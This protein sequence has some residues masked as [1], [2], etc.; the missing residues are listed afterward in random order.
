MIGTFDYRGRISDCQQWA[1]KAANDQ[2]KVLWKEMERFWREREIIRPI[3]GLTR[4]QSCNRIRSLTGIQLLFAAFSAVQQS[5]VAT[6][7]KALAPVLVMAT[8]E[9]IVCQQPGGTMSNDTPSSHPMLSCTDRLAVAWQDFLILCG[10]ILL[11]W[12]FVQS[13]WRKMMDIPGFVKTMPRPRL[14][15]GISR[16]HRAA[17]RGDLRRFDPARVCDRYAAHRALLCCS[18]IVATFSSH[19]YWNFPERSRR[20]RAAISGRTSR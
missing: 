17:G 16:L 2:A 6:R 15:S 8:I 12:I 7:T 5:H 14:L 3:S 9:Q 10:R 18:P 20:T 19:R 4:R 1:E 11:G 13:G